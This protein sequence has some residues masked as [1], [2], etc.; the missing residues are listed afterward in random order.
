MC[1]DA[2]ELDTET[3]YGLLSTS[4]RRHIVRFTAVAAATGQTP[5]PVNALAHGIAAVE[6][7]LPSAPEKRVRTVYTS[8]TQDRENRPSELSR[9]DD[10]GII[11]YDD[12]YRN[13][14]V[15]PGPNFV[16]V[17]A[18]MDAFEGVFAGRI[19]FEDGGK[20]SDNAA[21][22]GGTDLPLLTEDTRSD[23]GATGV[24]IRA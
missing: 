5:L 2:D 15:E 7:D 21:E 13:K 18:A 23:G 17:L 20:H 11:D 6:T 19:H 10:A 16:R 9:L 24:L 1:D 8:I 14:T 12:T 22:D 4:R 3:L